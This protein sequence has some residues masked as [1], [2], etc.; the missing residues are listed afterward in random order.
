MCEEYESAFEDVVNNH[1]PV[2]KC[3]PVECPNSC[4]IQNLQHPNVEEH[5]SSQCP[6]T[7]VECEFSDTGCDAK[8]YRKDLASH[9]TDNLVTHMSLLAMENRKL[10]Q[11]LQKQEEKAAMEN[12]KLIEQLQQ[13]EKELDTAEQKL[14]MESRKIEQLEKQQGKLV[15]ENRNFQLQLQKQEEETTTENREL[16]Q[17]IDRAEAKLKKQTEDLE[18][19]QKFVRSALAR[20]PP[21]FLGCTE[22]TL[23]RERLWKSEPFYDR[24]GGDKLSLTIIFMGEN[25]LFCV[26]RLDSEFEVHPLRKVKK[27]TMKLLAVRH[28]QLQIETFHLTVGKSPAEFDP[29]IF[30]LARSCHIGL[31]IFHVTTDIEYEYSNLEF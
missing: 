16:K 2:C 30:N 10:K 15:T 21:L 17:Q 18:S 28:G 14:W 12:G 29:S 27:V 26:S 4:G 20:V 13:Q 5:V 8:V 6:L 25:Y 7:Y 3:R 11:Q 19:E 31:V 23:R 24:I 22:E 1:A 9:L